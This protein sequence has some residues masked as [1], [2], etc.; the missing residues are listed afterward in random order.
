MKIKL[1][2]TAIMP[3]RAHA[4]DAGLDLY[5]PCDCTIPMYGHATIDT[6]VHVQLPPQSVGLI[7][8][9]SGLMR[10]GIT[11][12]GTI[13]EGYTGSLGVVLFNHSSYDCT[14][15]RGDR[16]AQLV[17]LPVLLPEIQLVHKLDKTER[18][19]NGFGSTG[20]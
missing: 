3:T 7:T 4:T 1:D 6:G 19:T 2:K 20:R 15:K 17:V 18:G 16:I 12:R 14:I 8:S 13:D 5:A 9:R 10:Q 11:T